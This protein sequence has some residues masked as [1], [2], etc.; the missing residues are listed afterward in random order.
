MI[1]SFENNAIPIEKLSLFPN[2]QLCFSKQKV[3]IVLIEKKF[4]IMTITIISRFTCEISPKKYGKK[5]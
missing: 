2:E 1:F 3:E 5:R 4:M